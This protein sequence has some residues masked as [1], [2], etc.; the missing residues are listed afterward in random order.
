MEQFFIVPVETEAYKSHQAWVQNCR[1]VNDIVN[2]LREQHQIESSLYSACTDTLLI[3][4]TK[5][6]EV[7]FAKQFTAAIYNDGLKQFKQNSPVGRA[8]KALG[9]KTVRRPIVPFWFSGNRGRTSSRL[10]QINGVVYCSIENNTLTA[11]EPKEPFVP[12]KAS[13]FWA[14]VE[15]EQ[16]DRAREVGVEV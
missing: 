1:E 5:D 9:V 4:P 6:D 16:A 13:E 7:K 3:V 8:W 11:L 10:C 14:A 12:I 15:A 2:Q